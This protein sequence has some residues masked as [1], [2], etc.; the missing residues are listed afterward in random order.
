MPTCALTDGKTPE[1]AFWNK[2]PNV[3]HLQEFSRKCWVLQQDKK[4][5]KLDL[6][7]QPFDFVG[8]DDSTKGYRYWMAGKF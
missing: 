6:R 2:K 5:K 1:E 3:S 4:I 7:S 8:I